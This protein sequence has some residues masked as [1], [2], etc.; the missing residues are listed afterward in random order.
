LTKYKYEFNY[1]S[2]PNWKTYKSLLD[3]AAQIKKDTA[4]VK[5]KDFIDLQSFIWVPGSEK[6][7]D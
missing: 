2:K 6:Y 4:D 3:F 7:V 1:H 5:P